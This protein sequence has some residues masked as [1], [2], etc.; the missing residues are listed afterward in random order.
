M[1]VVIM[2]VPSFGQGRLIESSADKRPV[3]VKRDVDRYDVVKI[4]QESSI[5]LENAKE[6]AF[7]ELRSQVIGSAAKYIMGRNVEGRSSDEIIRAVEN[8]SYVKNISSVAAI[9]TYW[10]HRLVKKED[11]Y[12]YYILYDFNDLEKKKIALE[13]DYNNSSAVKEVNNL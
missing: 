13:I 5:S 7:D 4:S 1:A 8:S 6:K 9:S 3:W 2:S 12:I 10:E 11:V